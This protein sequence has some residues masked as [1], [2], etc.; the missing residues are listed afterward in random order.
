MSRAQV[1]RPTR[2]PAPPARD[3]RRRTRSKAARRVVWISL[4]VVFLT[5]AG[6][7]FASWSSSPARGTLKGVLQAVGGVPG[8]SPRV[9]PGQ[10]TIR[11][12]NGDRGSIQVGS[13]GH[14]LVHPPVGTYDVS[15]RSPLSRGGS[16]ECLASRPVVVSQGATSTVT[17]ECQE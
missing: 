14:F 10:I 16:V 6:F 4:V 15:G 8:T 13:S 5:A 9:L 1:D 7:S 11:G 12:T 3:L 17:V 2:W